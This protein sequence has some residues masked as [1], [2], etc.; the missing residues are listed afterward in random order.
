MA[1]HP[2]TR[3]REDERRLSIR[4]LVIASIASLTAALITSR[5]WSAGTPIAAAIT[6]VLVSLVSEMLHRPTEKIA[7]RLTSD[8]EVLGRPAPMR[9]GREPAQTRPA[10]AGRTNPLVPTKR[11]PVKPP[12]VDSGPV[13]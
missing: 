5:F 2:Q 10:E 12:P 11:T 8:R 3:G 7:E 13:P 6:P 1:S 4:T 9:R